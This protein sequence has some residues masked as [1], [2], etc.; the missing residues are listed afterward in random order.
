[1][2]TI[3]TILLSTLIL[4]LAKSSNAQ[5][6]MK[7]P[8]GYT[9]KNGMKIIV[10]ENSRS[11]KAYASFTLDA[12]AFQNK[13][14]G[15]VELLNAVLNENVEKDANVLFMDNSAKLATNN[16]ALDQDLTAMA[17]L[18]ENAVINQKTFNNGKAKLLASLKMQD[19]DYDQT[20]NVNSI[21]VLSLAD[22]Q[23]FHAQISPEK[24]YLTVAGDVE[25]NNAKAAVKK[26]FGNWKKAD[27]N[28]SVSLSK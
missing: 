20:V 17:S 10:S 2:N 28:E 13:K 7:E 16:T 6:G 19:Y 12:Q 8:V 11:P 1:M 23:D 14:D 22:V 21:T 18:I 9:L 5:N 27:K 4:L 3:K 25:L 26:A 15:I 24:T